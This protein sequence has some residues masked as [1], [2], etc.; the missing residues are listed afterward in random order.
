ALA[1]GDIALAAQIGLAGV[2]VAY[3]TFRLEAMKAWFDLRDTILSTWGE[4]SLGLQ[5]GVAYVAGLF[6]GFLDQLIP[7]WRGAMEAIQTIAAA[8]WSNFTATASTAFTV[9]NAL[10]DG[11]IAKIRTFLKGAQVAIKAT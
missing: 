10:L 3:D 11:A 5:T 6:T 7:G 2:M 1:A 9:I 4:V 8:A